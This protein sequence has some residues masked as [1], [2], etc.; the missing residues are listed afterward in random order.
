LIFGIALRCRQFDA[1]DEVTVTAAGFQSDD[2]I[3]VRRIDTVTQMQTT[4]RAEV[5]TRAAESISF[6]MPA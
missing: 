3:F 6:I 1:G 2:D 5:I 4:L